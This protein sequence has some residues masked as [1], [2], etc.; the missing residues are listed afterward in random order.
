MKDKNLPLDNNTQSLD[1][2]T[3][4]YCIIQQSYEEKKSLCQDYE[5]KLVSQEE[6]NLKMSTEVQHLKT[7]IA[8]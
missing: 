1:E 4:E 6:M 7:V 5:K 3:K 2:L 8:V